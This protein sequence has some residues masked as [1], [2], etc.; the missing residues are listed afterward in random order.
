MYIGETEAQELWIFFLKQLALYQVL[1]GWYGEALHPG[2]LH[3][4]MSLLALTVSLAMVWVCHV[5]WEDL[6]QSG[7]G[8]GQGQSTVE[9][10][11]PQ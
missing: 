9:G 6:V 3:I 2:N 11:S 4:L 7:S 8:K 1:T 5:C 10:G